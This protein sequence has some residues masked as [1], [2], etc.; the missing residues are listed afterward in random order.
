M[1]ITRATFYQ[2]DPVR[3]APSLA[4]SSH[5]RIDADL[6][7]ISEARAYE[8]YITRFSGVPT[9]PHSIQS[10]DPGSSL[11]PRFE[12]VAGRGVDSQEGCGIIVPR[13]TE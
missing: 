11:S 12:M 3:L 6:Y 8:D 4:A 5:S 2:T 1:G 9:Q 13:T 10:L 7:G